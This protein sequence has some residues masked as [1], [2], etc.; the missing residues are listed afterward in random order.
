VEKEK[1]IG[2]TTI[3]T[4]DQ[5]AINK[6]PTS[7]L[8]AS[9]MECYTIFELYEFLTE[10]DIKITCP[11][12]KDS[13]IKKIGANSLNINSEMDAEG[14]TYWF[15]SKFGFE[16]Y[17]ICTECFNIVERDIVE[18]DNIRYVIKAIGYEDDEDFYDSEENR[19]KLCVVLK[20][21][22]TEEYTH[23]SG[24]DFMRLMDTR[25]VTYERSMLID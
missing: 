8:Q 10:N 18:I 24:S 13:L 9:T 14:E 25:Q 11:F 2:T 22:D 20:N 12:N 5:Q 17:Y 3:P 15:P 1:T 4:S 21:I 7:D 23:M 6:R 19:D 16:D